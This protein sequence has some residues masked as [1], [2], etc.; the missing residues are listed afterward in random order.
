MKNQNNK[1]VSLYD[2]KKINIDSDVRKRIVLCHGV[3]DLLHLGHIKYFQEAKSY[4]DVLIVTVTSDEYVR[5]GPGRPVFNAEHRA[6][7]I[8]AL[9][10][11]DYVAVNQWPTAIKTIELIK[12]NFYVKGSDYKNH[13]NDVTGNIKLE[14]EAVKKFGGEIKYTSGTTFSSTR[15]I[16]QNINLFNGRQKEY[17]NKIRKKY[18]LD[19]V[20][21]YFDKMMQQNILL[22][23][24]TII[25]EYVPC[26]ALGKAGKDSIMTL[27]KLKGEKYLG[28]TLAIA[29]HLAEFCSDINIVSY[30]G[31]CREYEK[32]VTENLKE[33]ISFTAISKSESPTIVKR[34]YLDS[35]NKAKIIGVYDINDTDINEAEENKLIDILEENID[36]TDSTIIAD[37]GHGLLTEKVID[38]VIKRSKYLCVNTQLNSANIGFHTISK[39]HKVD[40]VCMH[41]GEL[42]HDFR[43]RNRSIEELTKDLYDR[44]K[45]KLVTVT[46]GNQGALCYDVKEGFEQC[47]A[48]ANKIVDKVGA[49]DTLYA[50]TA[51]AFSVNM[52]HDISLLLGSLAATETVAVV[53]NSKY[54]DKKTMFKMIETVFK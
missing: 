11:V 35:E 7:A 28:G 1:I 48:F 16:N 12:P 43:S 34:R 42:R 21:E 27:Q 38:F 31:E 22:V 25:D 30:L 3:F 23:G 44:V 45:A 33:N 9:D 40:Y 49:G 26:N 54:L 29:N 51:L 5:R 39:Y 17:I 13:D 36:Q 53:G 10:V 2:L 32:Y 47:P 37:Y 19:T 18:S 15:L 50:L 41:E 14:E 24:E 46:Q 6:E 4:G 52:P 8:A 20:L